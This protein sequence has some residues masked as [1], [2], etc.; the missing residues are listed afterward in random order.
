MDNNLI[1]L[2][3]DGEHLAIQQYKSHL[4]TCT[5][6]EVIEVLN[7]IIKEE[8]QHIQM[9]QGLINQNRYK[10]ATDAWNKMYKR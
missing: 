8:E 4:A 3:I 7:H 5:D 6:P 1:Q 10:V 9:L 2:D